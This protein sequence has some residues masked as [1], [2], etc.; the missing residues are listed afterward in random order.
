MLRKL[1]RPSAI[2]IFVVGAVA[3]IRDTYYNGHDFE[4][5]WRAGGDLL[6]GRDPYSLAQ[7]RGMVFKYPPWSLPFFLPWSW[8]PLPIAKAVWGVLEI[9][10]LVAAGRW[11]RTLGKVS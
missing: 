2:A 7:P 10:S 4:V 9:G 1:A 8:I 6:Q 11:L 3:L 5:F